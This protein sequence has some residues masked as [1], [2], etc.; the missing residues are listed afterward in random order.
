MYYM[1]MLVD[2]DGQAL[3]GMTP[4]SVYVDVPFSKTVNASDGTSVDV[5]PTAPNGHSTILA[6]SVVFTYHTHWVYAN[7]NQVNATWTLMLR[8]FFSGSA[9]PVT[10]YVRYVYA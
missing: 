9:F 10:G 2:A 6:A 5:T 1:S 3:A 7:L 8:N 4:E